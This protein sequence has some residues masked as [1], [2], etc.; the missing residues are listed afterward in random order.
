[1]A[2]IFC[3]QGWLCLLLI[4]GVIFV[5]GWT[6]A[7]NAIA[8]CVA[9]GALPLRKAAFLAAVFNFLGLILFPSVSAAVGEEIIAAV[10]SGSAALTALC[11]SMTAVVAFAVIAWFFG[12]PTSESHALIAALSGASFAT[13][14]GEGIS[15][16]LWLLVALGI[17]ITVGAGFLLG[18]CFQKIMV[19]SG[20]CERK[21]ALARCEIFCAALLS[22]IHGAQDGQKFSALMVLTIS[23]SLGRE[24]NSLY[25]TVIC[26]VLLFLGTAV[27]GG[28][29]IKK[30]GSG[31]TT[32][33]EGGGVS[34]D[35]AAFISI[36]VCTLFGMPVSTTH[37]KTGAILGVGAARREA[38]LKT[39]S[40]I[41]SLWLLTFPACFFL[42]FLFARLCV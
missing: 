40:E 13:S 33:D 36:F 3:S 5:N 32:V 6:D 19:K 20:L 4:C 21:K 14:G 16:K 2:G 10:P 28:R 12:I 37:T 39:F 26:A 23:L 8:T 25:I 38:N 42:S 1:M 24:I 7:P 22:F 34:A 18:L 31:I 27:G 41:F 15:L 9:G 29:I 11:A 17:V 30:V 35:A